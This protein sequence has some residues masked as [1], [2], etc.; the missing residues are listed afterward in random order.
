MI[1]PIFPPFPRPLGV[2]CLLI[3]LQI[4]VGHP[5][6]GLVGLGSSMN[7]K[8]ARGLV[9]RDLAVISNHDA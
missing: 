4:F 1:L 6:A 9:S 8:T 3:S 2:I 7:R 5:Y